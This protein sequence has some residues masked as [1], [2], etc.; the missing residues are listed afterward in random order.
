MPLPLVGQ[1]LRVLRIGRGK[2]L[3]GCA[4]LNAFPQ[5]ARCGKGQHYLLACAGL[6]VACDLGE[7]IAQAACRVH[8]HRVTHRNRRL[9]RCGGLLR[10]TARQHRNP[11]ISEE[12]PHTL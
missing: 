2:H 11:S 6:V 9:R 4:L 12:T 5:Q 3:G 10:G 1:A 8:L 7:R